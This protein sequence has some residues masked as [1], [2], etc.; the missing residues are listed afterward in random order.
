MSI[1][2]GGGGG[3]AT[4]G[5]N[6]GRG[7]HGVVIIRYLIPSGG[8]FHWFSFS[9]AWRKHDKLWTPKLIIPKLSE[10]FSY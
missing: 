5:N 6:P 4:G 7:G 3:G 8:F 9:E 10:G 1:R 2:I